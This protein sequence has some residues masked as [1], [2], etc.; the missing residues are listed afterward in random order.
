[1]STIIDP[2]SV[3]IHEPVLPAIVD[4]VLVAVYETALQAIGNAVTVAVRISG[5]VHLAG[6]LAHVGPCPRATAGALLGTSRMAVSIASSLSSGDSGKRGRER[7]DA[8]EHKQLT[9]K[10]NSCYADTLARTADY[11]PPFPPFG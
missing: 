3:A 9:H 7:G 5:T 11:N 2:V 8:G 4:S 10:S 1:L 6:T